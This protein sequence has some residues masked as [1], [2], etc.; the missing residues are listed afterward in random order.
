[1][2]EM[3]ET[4]RKQYQ[5]DREIRERQLEFE[6]SI[7]NFA[8]SCKDLKPIDRFFGINWV[9][10]TSIPKFLKAIFLFNG[11]ELAYRYSL[12]KLYISCIRF[13]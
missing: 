7:V 8:K 5:A 9:I 3:S 2:T 4:E 1:M 6:T 11:T 13:K 12:L 10:L